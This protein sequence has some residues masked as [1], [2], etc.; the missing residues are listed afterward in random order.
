MTPTARR[1]AALGAFIAL[2]AVVLGA[3]GAHALKARLAPEQLA[4][5]EVGVRYQ[6][7]HAF[8]LIL[9]A[10]LHDRAAIRVA[11][12][13]SLFVAGIVLFSGSIYLLA[14]LGWKFLGPV[15]PLGGLC[16]M[17]GWLV[18]GVSLLRGRS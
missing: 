3:F 14:T 10:L 2:L 8:A 12:P 17:A 4:S 9:V 11:L 15:T 5:F 18:L 1:I 6:L 16:L 7:Y 13:A